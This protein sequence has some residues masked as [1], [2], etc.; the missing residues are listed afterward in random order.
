MT[1]RTSPWFAAL[2]LAVGAN[3]YAAPV[4]ASD[5]ATAFKPTITLRVASPDQ[6]LADIRYTAELIARFAPTEKDA[7]EFVN[8]PEAA[9]TRTLG[10][11]W[12]KAIDT[13]RPILAYV[14]LDAN[15]PAST[16]A[17]LIPVKDE[18]GFRAIVVALT[19]KL[20]AGPDGV[21]RFDVPG[22]RDADGK[23]VNGYLR[24]ANN[25]AYVTY[26]NP[27]TVALN[28]IPPPAQVVAGDPT[29]AISYRMYLDRMPDMFRQQALAGVQQFKAMMGGDVG[30]GGAMGVAWMQMFVFGAPL[31]QLFPLAEPAV[32]DGRELTFDVRFDRKRLNLSFEA[33]VTP[34]AGSELSKL[35]GAL[36][37]AISLFPQMLPDDLA[38]RGIIR[39]T[40]P[41]G[42][43]KAV[44][45]QVEAGLAQFPQADPVWGAFAAK[46]GE[47]FLPTIRAGEIDFSGGLRGP[48]KDDRYGIIA[49]LRLA[50]AAGV[51]KAFRDVVKA[52]PQ[53][54][55]AMFKLDAATVSGVKVHQILPAALPEPAKSL[56]GESTVHIAFRPDGVIA[57]VGEGG[58]AALAAGLTATPQPIAQSFMDASGRKLIPLVTKIDADAGKKF[59][60]FLGTELD[61]VPLMEMAVEG[62]STLK[63]HYGNGLATFFPAAGLFAFRA[64]AAD[65][66]APRAVAVPIAPAPPAKPGGRP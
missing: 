28:R 29:A 65:V 50:D 1:A 55:Q 25:Y 41:E 38:A 42:L 3:L 52:L 53:N 66:A 56:F 23:P 7:K 5:P 9:L 11:D 62:G 26:K 64:M 60:A 54:D 58:S 51:E 63:V 35:T 19:G 8:A 59:K 34:K 61:R 39:G 27:A 15:V 6:I 46:I 21:S 49:G 40:I 24:F 57:A 45:P 22:D 4:P 12:R 33:T 37:P 30:G 13:A 10:A 47:S 20:D 36:K 16:G 32:R 14:T 2:M 17:V 18:A 31:M 43:R 48:G 44:L